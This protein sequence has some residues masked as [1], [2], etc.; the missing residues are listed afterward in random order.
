MGDAHAK[1]L[2]F[3]TAGEGGAIVAAIF[4]GLVVNHCGVITMMTLLLF[5]FCPMMMRVD[6]IHLCINFLRS[7]AA[8][9]IEGGK[10]QSLA[11]HEK[12][13]QEND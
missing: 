6:A 5:R 7:I 10:R 2:G 12:A 13:C 8:A 1:S 9:I 4:T 3:A 11:G